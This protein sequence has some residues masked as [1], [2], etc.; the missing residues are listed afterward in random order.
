MIQAL[1]KQNGTARN[2]IEQQQNEV[3]EMLFNDIVYIYAIFFVLYYKHY[4]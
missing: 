1:V 4:I 2:R 3:C